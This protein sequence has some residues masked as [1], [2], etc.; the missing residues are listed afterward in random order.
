MIKFKELITAIQGAADQAMHAISLKNVELLS[1]YFEKPE[2]KEVAADDPIPTY[3][4]KMVRISYPR[5]TEDGPT[6]H[7]VYVPLISISPISNI[8]M[9]EMEVEMDIELFEDED[10]CL[11]V[12][13]P[14]EHKSFFG[15]ETIS[16]PTPNAK[17][18]IKITGGDRPTGVTAIIDGYNRALKGQIP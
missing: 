14:S 10:Q 8:Q 6:T 13:F 7:D 3:I 9:S 18:K 2:E 5:Q 12:N 17:V 15:R 11:N 16:H 1:S 4:P